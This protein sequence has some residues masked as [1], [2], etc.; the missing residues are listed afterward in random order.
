MTTPPL[1]AEQLTAVAKATEAA[2]PPG[3][4]FLLITVPHTDDPKKAMCQYTAS[5][6]RPTAISILKTCLFRWG[7]NEEWMKKI[8]E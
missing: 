8:H 7:I 2:L 3:H 5:I 6:E 1:T 4:Y